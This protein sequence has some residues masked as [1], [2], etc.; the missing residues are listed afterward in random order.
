MSTSK[1][2]HQSKPTAS[3]VIALARS[4]GRRKLTERESKQVLSAVGIEV[5]REELAIDEDSAADIAESIGY[6]VVLKISSP[7]ILHKSDAGGV[8]VGLD[9]AAGVRCAYRTIMTTVTTKHPD[10]HIDGILVCEM[11][12]GG[13]ETIVGVTNT[14]PFGPT[15]AFGLGGVFVEV[16]K[17][18]TFRIAPIDEAEARRMLDDIGAS[19]MLDGV[20]GQE[21]TDR[22]A[23]A[24]T[25]ERVSEFGTKYHKDIEELDINP[26]V[27]TGDR[28]VALDG[29]ITL[30]ADDSVSVTSPDI[31]AVAGN[32]IDAVLEPRSLAVIGASTNPTKSGHTILKNVIENGYEGD[33][34]PI[35]PNADEILGLKAYPSILDVPGEV[36]LVFFLLPGHFVP[37]LFKD[38]Y[39]KGVKAACIISGGFRE[40]GEAGAKAQQELVK[41][42]ERTGIRCLGPNTIGL[43][44]MKE[45][46]SASF[47]FFDNWEDGPISLGGQSGVFAGAVADEIMD[48]KV[49]RIGIGRSLAFGN[50]VDLDEC[51]FVEWAW[52][53]DQTE[54]IA[55]Y[56]ESINNPRRF[57]SIANKAKCDKPVIVLKPG[58]TQQGSR[59]SASHTGSLAMDDDVLDSALRQYGIIRAYTLEDFVEYMKAFSYAPLPKGDRVGVVTFSGANGV[60]CSDE[61]GEADFGLAQLTDSTKERCKAFLPDWQPAANPLDLWAALGSGNRVAHEEGILSILND[62]NVDAVIVILLAL[63][64]ANF[65]GIREIFVRAKK[66]QPDKPVYTVFLGGKVKQQ[67]LRE[68][69]GLNIP[70]FDTTHVAVKALQA[71]RLY[72]LKRDY[73]QPDPNILS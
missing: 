11:V 7:D 38:C 24:R 13:V 41:L 10:A 63:D 68:I 32:Q 61:L 6:P 36:D 49:Q 28:V 50:K 73:L 33:V 12:S 42:V 29:L 15:V 69:D 8:K 58:R 1:T 72:A 53:D 55:M 25:L 19:A 31:G 30:K 47:V 60:L 71:A 44:N 21:A 64:M 43:M 70:H 2:K 20:R 46:L 40:V 59:A 26:L 34:Y 54:V 22:N 62:D 65:E 9:D 45:K 37:T 52:Q 3:E 23:L 66:E 56:L 17:D 57:L 51:D 18:I 14:P 67:W 35:N 48:R 4:E 27:A 5:T 16:L 39:K